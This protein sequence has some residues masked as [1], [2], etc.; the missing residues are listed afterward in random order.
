VRHVLILL[1][2]HYGKLAA[3]LLLA[4][5][6]GGVWWA[7]PVRPRVAW[8]IPGE[9]NFAGFTAD[10]RLLATIGDPVTDPSAG[11]GICLWDVATGECKAKLDGMFEGKASAE[12]QFSPDGRFLIDRKRVNPFVLRVDEVATRQTIAQFF[13]GESP[14]EPA[15]GFC[16]SPDGKTLVCV[17]ADSRTHAPTLHF[18]DLPT[19]QIRASV[20]RANTAPIL[21]S[22]DGSLLATATYD[23]GRSS[24][25]VAIIIWDS[26]RAQERA[27][28]PV[29]AGTELA[30][31]IFAA[32]SKT[33]ALICRQDTIDPG[34]QLL[35]WDIAS[36]SLLSWRDEIGKLLPAA[37]K[38]TNLEHR[39][40]ARLGSGDF[41]ICEL[42]TG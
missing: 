17:G 25:I 34:F 33:V 36:N 26:V 13:C 14:P 38:K 3:A 16:F 32:N 30:D 23:S 37:S 11:F 35:F 19:R 1:R 21:F 6:L 9:Y 7:L 29:P 2:R 22:P 42:A 31:V 4:L 5:A 41:R 15:C 39:Y 8:R 20:H 24:R 28:F 40:F 27:H 18:W 10:G 12:H